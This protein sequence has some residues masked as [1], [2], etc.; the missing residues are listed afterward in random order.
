MTDKNQ[1]Q[2]TL[3]DEDVPESAF[4]PGGAPPENIP[5]DESGDNYGVTAEE[6]TSLGVKKFNRKRV[7][8][9]LCI[10]FAVVAGGGLLL[11]SGG[12]RGSGAAENVSARPAHTPSDFLR[13]QLNRI[14][15]MDEAGEDELP[16]VFFYEPLPEVT[17]FSGGIQHIAQHRPV[18]PPAAHHVPQQHHHVPV[19]HPQAAHAQPP[20]QPRPR[21][22]VPQHIEGSIF[23]N[24]RV[25]PHQSVPSGN[26]NTL[27]NPNPFGSPN[28]PNAHNAAANHFLQQAAA[29]Q[30]A[31][32]QPQAAQN[33]GQPFFDPAPGAAIFGGRFLGENSLWPGTMIPGILETAINTSLP[34]NVLARVTHNV[35]DSQTG[36]RLLIPQGTILIARYNDSVSYAQ[37]R[38]QI[39]WDTLIRPDGFFVELQGMNSVDRRGMSGQPGTLHQNWFEYLKAAGIITMFSF[40]NSRMNE[41]V[42]DM[43]D[44]HTAAAAAQANQAFVN[45]LSGGIISR[46]MNIQ[47]VITVDSGTL[48]NIMLNRVIYLPPVPAPPVTQRHSL[49]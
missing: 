48:I 2:D 49:R 9:T 44:D 8:M 39:V 5:P 42:A 18:P 21:S 12:S 32:M 24:T 15:R 34:G 33:G 20:Q 1:W 10:A 29:M 16:P 45:Q 26:P 30:A 31:V 36:T 23:G 40:A 22:I 13:T 14:P 41:A 3:H 38:V 27:A 37:R 35:F 17:P 19:H 7:L 25:L 28:S 11:S 43:A 4:S 46:A 6:A 47:P